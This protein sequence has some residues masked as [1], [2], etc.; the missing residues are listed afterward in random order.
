MPREQL[1]PALGIRVFASRELRYDATAPLGD[2]RPAHVRA[3]SGLAF[4][5]APDADGNRVALEAGMEVTAFEPEPR[6]A[7]EGIRSANR[8]ED[9]FARRDALF[10]E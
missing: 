1:D 7:R 5:T 8:F 4:D 2:D 6:T 10:D 3:A 9:L